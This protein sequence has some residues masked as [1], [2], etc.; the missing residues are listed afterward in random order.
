MAKPDKQP[1]NQRPDWL[2]WRL[3]VIVLG[4][5]SLAGWML[6]KQGTGAFS[7][8]P[9]VAALGF[10]AWLLFGTSAP[11]GSAE[12]FRALLIALAVALPI[13]W[14]VGE[15]Y[16]IPSGS[17]EPTLHGVDE[18][19]KGDRVFVNKWRYGTRWPLNHSG[20]PFL[21]KQIEYADSRIWNG[22]DIERWDIVV[23]KSIEEGVV[24]RGQPNTLVKRVIGLPGERVQIRNGCIEINGE[25]LEL[26]DDMPDI[27]Y[28]S[29]TYS[30][31]P[32]GVWPDDEYSLIPDDHY[33]LL[34]DNS[35]SSR[36]GRYWGFVP[37]EHIIGRV[38]AIWWPP[39]RWRD[40]TGFSRT[41]WWRGLLLTL[42]LF[43]LWRLFVGRSWHV[44]EN[45]SSTVN[46]KEHLIINRFALGLPIPF[47]SF[48]MSSRLPK[49]GALVLYR[50]K[51][52]N[53]DWRLAR[54]AGLP[55]E[56]AR[57]DDPAFS[58]KGKYGVSKKKEHMRIPDGHYFL[59]AEDP[60]A[61]DSRV[62]GWVP[63]ERLVGV[64]SIVWW[65]LTR[66]R[67]VAP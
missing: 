55:G 2:N 49:K 15:P 8:M 4:T 21:R 32:Y 24:E 11:Q 46:A 43:T 22:K 36:D 1:V 58:A 34:G 40:F 17:M 26:P 33:F 64:A 50:P 19:M 44:Y 39:P 37:N 28:T 13:R 48:R 62:E 63:H 12:W 30:T 5:L 59:L 38:S 66:V 67:R 20:V 56:D 9:M 65:P 27:Y 47:T 29:N 54:V 18:F 6:W 41:Y 60:E 31:A 35:G 52:K 42:G 10:I 51:E 61:D 53:A 25:P 3:G 45:E 7:T 16:K 14:M 23:F 57:V